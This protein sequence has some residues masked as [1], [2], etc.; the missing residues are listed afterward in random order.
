MQSTPLL[1]ACAYQKQKSLWFVSRY[2]MFSR[3]H[4]EFLPLP[5]T[6]RP[7]PP[8]SGY[9]TKK[10]LY[11]AESVSPRLSVLLEASGLVTPIRMEGNNTPCPEHLY[12]IQIHLP[13]RTRLR[14]ILRKML[15]RFHIYL[16]LRRRSFRPFSGK[17]VR[18]D[19]FGL[20]QLQ[21]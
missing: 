10:P 1:Q 8:V 15:P 18:E 17:R 16:L 12:S 21:L 13:Y 4:S 11:L 9:S 20:H 5:H 7:F 14:S 6:L 19:H 2:F 3:V